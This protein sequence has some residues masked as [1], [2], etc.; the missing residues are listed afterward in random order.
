ML[1]KHHRIVAAQGSAEQPDRVLG[2]RRHRD[3][4]AGRVDELHLVGL[5]VPRIAAFE[6]T[7]RHPHDHRRGKAVVGPPAHRPA[8]VDLL[9]RGIGIF[10]ELDL[11]HGEQAA[12]RHADRAADNAFLRQR[13]VEDA[14]VAELLLQ[15]QSHRMDAALR[16]DVLAEDQH[17]GI[18]LELDLERAADRGDHVDPA[19]L[20]RGLARSARQVNAPAHAAHRLGLVARKDVGRDGGGVGNRDSLGLFAHR[21]DL[22]GG[23]GLDFVPLVLVEQRGDEMR[24]QLGQRIARPFA[25]D[26]GLG[27]VGLRVLETVP[28]EARDG[29]PDQARPLPGPHVRDRVLDHRGGLDRLGAVAVED[30]EAREAGKVGGDVGARRLEGRRDRDPVAIVLDIEQHRQLLRRRDRQRRPETV[31]RDRRLAAQ[32]DAD[33]AVIVGIAQRLG[34]VFDR[35]RPASGRGV[36]RADA[37]AHRQRRGSV[38]IGVIEHDADIAPVRIAARSR[39]RRSQRLDQ[40]DAERQQDRARTVIAADRVV[41]VRQ[42]RSQQDLRH[43]VAARGKLVE[44]LLFWDEPRFLE[45]VELSR[46]LDETRHG[47]PVD[48][49]IDVVLARLVRILRLALHGG[50]ASHHALVRHRL[51]M[52]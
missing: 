44:H 6:E 34:A 42:L 39:H 5:A 43:V 23:I 12:H 8:I 32:N 30:L 45:M 26:L 1:Q 40:V 41:P 28:L 35:L 21:F 4:P 38:G 15:A 24:L 52:A 17:L 16:T 25:R 9:H 36:L 33:R 51:S 19:A 22:G 29:Q 27:L 31:G 46:Q 49:G 7:D 37:A 13:S 11:G 20:G 14:G 50:F 3:L 18:D 10:T 47:A 2:V 48:I